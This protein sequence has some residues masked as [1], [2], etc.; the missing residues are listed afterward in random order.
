M[1]ACHR[2]GRRPAASEAHTEL[3]VCVSEC[4]RGKREGRAEGGEGSKR[5]TGRE[6]ERRGRESGAEERARGSHQAGRCFQCN[7][8]M[9][10][11]SF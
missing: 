3:C 11:S 6:R 1:V 5:K 9:T 4:E 2:R 8:E 7:Q 10:D